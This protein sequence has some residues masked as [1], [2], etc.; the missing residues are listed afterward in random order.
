MKGIPYSSPEALKTGPS[1][2]VE[3]ATKGIRSLVVGSANLRQVCCRLD[4]VKPNQHSGAARGKT[5]DRRH[6]MLTGGWDP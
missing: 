2:E 5:E 3:M 4:R 1:W 6:P